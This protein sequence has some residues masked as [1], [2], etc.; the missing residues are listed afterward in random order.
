MNGVVASFNSHR[1]LGYISVGEE[2]YLFHC[3]EIVDGTREIEI[4]AQVT[5]VVAQRFGNLEASEI[6]KL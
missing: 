3:A 1:G 4:G 5:F 2:Q 6:I